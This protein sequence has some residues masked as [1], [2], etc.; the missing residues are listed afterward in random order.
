MN[1]FFRKLTDNHIFLGVV[2]VITWGLVPALAKLGSLSGGLTTMYVSWINILGIL[3]IMIFNGSIRKLNRQVNYARVIGIG[4]AWPLIYSI[5][6]FTT[7]DKGGSSLTTLTNYL[8]P[9]F[10]LVFAY[11][12]SSKRF[13]LRS[14]VVVCVAVAGV[15]I[16]S[17]IEGKISL[18]LAAIPWG[19]TAAAMQGLFMLLIEDD[20]TDAWVFVFI[21]EIV[22]A[23]G[24]TVYVLASGQF[25]VPD[26]PTF[27]Y[28]I[29]LGLLAGTIGFWAFTKGGKISDDKGPDYRIQFIGILC[30]TPLVQVAVLPYLGV[31]NISPVKWV[32]VLMIT[33]ALIWHRVASE[34]DK[35]RV[36]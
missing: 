30:L 3:G 2:V 11:F 8:W 19:I 20:R 32:G 14:W 26:M 27:G 1:A 5:A 24:A 33:G 31:E 34:K 9:V 7:V 4:I 15:G 18:V 10:Y 17:F 6:Y 12:L 13:S 25:L 21:I 29:Y 22:T 23:V 36:P 16:P 28:L 35:L